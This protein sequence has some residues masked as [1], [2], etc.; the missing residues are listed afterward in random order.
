MNHVLNSLRWK[1]YG[2]TIWGLVAKARQ[3]SQLDGCCCSPS[4]RTVRDGCSGVTCIP[5]SLRPEGGNLSLSN[6]QKNQVAHFDTQLSS[7]VTLC[8]EG[9][10]LFHPAI[11]HPGALFP[12]LLPRFQHIGSL[13]PILLARS[14]SLSQLSTCALIHPFLIFS[15]ALALLALI[16][17]LGVGQQRRKP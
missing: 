14:L 15:P 9:C 8:A 11:T 17:N 1:L 12:P 13:S 2:A 10:K 3:G 16:C 6:S 7:V 5:G 4:A